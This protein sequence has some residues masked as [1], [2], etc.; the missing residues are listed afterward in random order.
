SFVPGL[1]RIGNWLNDK[2]EHKRWLCG[3]IDEFAIWNLKLTPTEIKHLAEAGKPN[4]LW[5][6]TPGSAA[7]SGRLRSE[8]T[9]SDEP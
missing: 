9:W 7:A 8:N 6:V 3:R 5:S 2:N 4:S 1:S